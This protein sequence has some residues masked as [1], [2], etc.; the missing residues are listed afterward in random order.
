MFL[1]LNII[2]IFAFLGIG[3]LASRDRKRIPWKNIAVLLACE[4]IFAWF[5]TTFSVGR[6]GIKMAVEGFSFLLNSAYAGIRFAV[7]DWVNVSQMNFLTAALLPILFVVPLFDI[8]N[9]IGVLPFI[10]RWCGK[11]LAAISHVSRFE[12]FFAIEMM[13]LGNSEAIGVSRVQMKRMKAERNLAIAMMSMSC[14]SAAMIGIY[15]VMMPADLVLTAVPL[16]AMNALLAIQLLN[17]TKVLPEEDIIYEVQEKGEKEPFFS[18]LSDSILGAGKIILI[19]FANV[20]AFVALEDFLN[21]L[22]GALVTGLSLETIFGY[23]M[24]PFA[25]LLGL[26]TDEAFLVAQYMGEKLVTNEV[27]VMLSVKEHLSEYS[28]HAVAVMTLFFTSFANFSTLGMVLGC[29]KGFVDEESNLLIGRNVWR[30]FVSG[31]L[32]SLLT[33]AIGGIF[34][35]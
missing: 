29:L 17:P 2:G 13:F 9:Y 12:S 5:L 31:I 14:V 25:W 24:L 7:P 32:V 30:I 16:N 11:A 10:V 33:A 35:W 8:L 3:A 26:Q 19:I 6:E 15:S 1:L 20:I 23:F 28:T 22:L 18:F 4:V 21:V 27:V 34:F